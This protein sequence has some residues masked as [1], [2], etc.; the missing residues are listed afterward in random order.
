MSA[1]PIYKVGIMRLMVAF[2]VLAACKMAF[3]E[4]GGNKRNAFGNRADGGDEGVR[5]LIRTSFGERVK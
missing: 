1:T 3:A 4:V 5:E 2:A